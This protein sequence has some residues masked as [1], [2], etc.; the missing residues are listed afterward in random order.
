M[1]LIPVFIWTLILW[2]QECRGQVTV[3][4]TPAVKSVLPGET[5][6][7]NCRTSPAVHGGNHIFWYLQKPGEAPKLLIKYVNQLQSG[8]PARFS[9]SG[10]GSDFTLTISGVQTEDAGDY[11]C[12]SDHSG[13]VFTQCYRVVQ[14]PPSVR[15]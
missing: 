3:T 15:L 6:T 5:V 13:Y 8:F 1:T 12:Q 4:Q 9:G 10:S 11:Y 2:T 7:I 14:K